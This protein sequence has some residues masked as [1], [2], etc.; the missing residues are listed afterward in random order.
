[1]AEVWGGVLRRLKPEA[2]ERAVA[3][4]ADSVIHQSESEV[5][6]AVAWSVVYACKSVSQTLHTCTPSIIT[7]LLN[8]HLS[9]PPSSSA[10]PT[11]KT[12]TLLRRLFTALIHHVRNAENFACV[13]DVLVDRFIAMA[14]ATTPSPEDDLEPLR[15]MMDLISIPAAVRNGSRLTRKFFCLHSPPMLTF[16]LTEKHAT[17]LLA[18]FPPVLT[19][20]VAPP[21]PF[22]RATLLR[23]AT[24]LLTASPDANPS[25]WMGKGRDVLDTVWTAKSEATVLFAISLTGAL[26]ELGW[27]GWRAIGI[28]LLLRLSSKIL[29]AKDGVEELQRRTVGLIAELWRAKKLGAG[30]GDVVWRNCVETWGATQLTDILTLSSFFSQSSGISAVLVQSCEALLAAPADGSP[31][32]AGPSHA[33]FVGTCMRALSQRSAT[34][35]E[36]LDLAA[37][38]RTCTA[39]GSKW[40]ESAD[41]LEALAALLGVRNTT[42]VDIEEIYPA[43]APGVLSH[44]RAL[45]LGTLR[46]LAATQ[47]S[48]AREVVKRCLAGEE[49]PLEVQGVRERVLRIGRVVTVVKDKQREADV[50]PDLCARWLIA[51]LK[52]N[53]R[54][55]WSPAAGALAQ[56]AQ[57]FGDEIWRL[58]FLELQTLY[59]SSPPNDTIE[60]S[61]EDV[62]EETGDAEKDPWEEE[63]TW[64]DPS[65][66]KLRGAVTKWLSA[67]HDVKELVKLQSQGDR[68]DAQTYESQLLFALGECPTLV[69]K[70]NRDIVPFFLDL[71]IPGPDS[72][73]RLPRQK[74]T[75]W[76]TLF[77]K[78]SNPKALHSTDAL[79]DLYIANL[80]H[81]DRALQSIAL[82]CIL[83]YKS[84]HLAAYESQMR[85]FLDDTRWRD[86]L[87][88]LDLSQVELQDRAEVVP[89]ITRLLFGLMLEKKGRSRGADRRAAVLGVLGG[90]TDEE[91]GLVVDLMLRSL[92]SDSTTRQQQ[93]FSVCD[94]PAEVS[95]KQQIGFIGLLGDVIRNLGPRLVAYWP[96][97]LGTTI[98]F[99][100]RA[101]ARINS[102]GRAEEEAEIDAEDE[103]DIDEN[104]P[105]SSGSK[106]LRSIRQLGLKRLAD[107]LRCPVHFDYAPYMQA[108]FPAFISPQNTQAPSS[109]LELFYVWTLDGER[110]MFLTQYDNLL[111]PKIYDCLIAT[112]VKP[113]VVSKIFDIVEKLLA[114]S[115]ID[116]NVSDKVVK[117]HVSLLLN[118]LAILVER[119]KGTASV[120]SQLGQRQI[121]ILSEI[122]Q[123]STDASQAS[124]LLTLFAPLLR[125]PPKVVPEKVKVN[126]LNIIG[127]LMPLIPD[128]SVPGS[129]IYVKTFELLSQL[130]QSLRFRPA[131]ISLVNSLRRLSLLDPSLERLAQILESL[132]AYSSRRVDEPDFDRRLSAFATLNETLFKSLS[133]TEWL[134]IIYNPAELAIRNN[135][136]FAMRHFI[137]LVAA[138]ISP[139]F[140]TMFNKVLFPG[141]KNGLRSKNE[142]VRSEI[143]GVLAYAVT[144]CESISFLQEM[145]VL[146]AGGDEEANFF[147]NIHHIQIHR[148]SRAL[149]RLADQCDEGHLRSNTLAEI[150]VPLVG[151]YITA[152]SAVDHHLVTDAILTTGRM[153]KHLTWGAYY[154]LVQKYL[155]LSRAKD[156]SERVYVRTVVS[157]LDNFH[158]PMEEAIPVVEDADEGEEEENEGD[159][160]VP[161]PALPIPV[162][163]QSSARIADAVNLRL[164]PTLLNH[165]EKRDATT[166]D[167]TRIPIAIGIVKVAKYLPATTR[168]PQIARLL[169][170]LSQVLRSKSQ[171]TRDLTRDTLSRIAVSLGPS[172][173]PLMLR[174]MRAALLRGPQL[175]VLAY[176]THALLVHVSSEEHSESFGNLDDCVNDVAYIS[177]EVIFGESAKDVMADEFKTKMR[178]VR[179]SSAKGLDAFGIVAKYIT[180]PRISSLL[181]PIR[182]IMQQTESVKVMQLVE[183]VLKRNARFLKQDASPTQGAGQGRRHRPDQTYRWPKRPDHYANNSFRFVT[184]GLDLFN[185]ALR[186]N[187]LDF[188]EPEIIKRLESMVVVIGNTLYSSTSPV[189]VFGL[190]AAAGIINRFQVFVQQIIDIVKQAGS[191]ESEV[192]QVAFKSL[193]VILRDGPAVQ[194]YL[195]ELLTPDLE[196]PSR[197]ASVFT[198]L[199]AIVARKFVVPEIYDVMD[200][201][202]D[203]MVTSQSPQVQ[204][205]CRSGKGRLRNQM[206]FLAKNLSYEY[207]S[208]RKSVLELLGAVLAKFEAGLVRE[209]VDLLFV[210]LVMV[211]AN[212]DSTKCREMAAQL[213]KTLFTRLDDDRRRVIISHLHSWASQ[214]SQP[215]LTRVSSQVYGL[216]IDVLGVDALTFIPGMLEDIEAS[217]SRSCQQLTD[218]ETNEEEAMDVDLEWQLPYHSLIVLSKILRVFPTLVTESEK[219]KWPSIVAHLLF[220]HAWVRTASCRLLGTLFTAVPPAPPQ[221]LLESSPVSGAGMREVA[222]KLCTQ[223]KSEHLDEALSLQV[224]KNLFYIG[225]CFY[226]VPLSTTEEAEKTVSN[227]DEDMQ[228][229]KD[230]NPL[231]WLFS[232]LSYQIRS[233][234][235]A[236]RNRRI[237]L[238][239]PLAAL[240][241]FAAMAAYM[242]AGRLEKF[243]VHILTPAYRIAEDD[244]IRDSQMDEL[245]TVCIELQDL[246]QSKVGTTKFSSAYNQIRQSVL[247]V[248]RERKATKVLQVT[249]NPEAAARRKLQRNSIK[250][251]SR[252]RKSSVFA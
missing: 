244:T 245:K 49:V 215:Q 199:R 47:P 198:M 158:F 72:S 25:F 154:A 119:T 228:D 102:A 45:R 146:L 126:L 143:L 213:I 243:L 69:Q 107:F 71:A 28:P 11:P 231:P 101:Q 61:M 193:A 168:E 156:A 12:Y 5:Q 77:S 84:P 50:G 105:T 39:A 203:I 166:E 174:E 212:D 67:R 114:F 165:L 223:L 197:Q 60:Q 219:V 83:T 235:I 18:A 17:A 30:D 34:E 140:E 141:L 161:T 153:A 152:T 32:V 175:H 56:M 51:Q 89:V 16:V 167:T 248:Q 200:K 227:G 129:V 164:L 252:K 37:W 100:A 159:E 104:S 68:L 222:N 10:D 22:V 135:A 1:M 178:E 79:R 63:R 115:T 13:G 148:R 121:S 75:A 94:V 95:E 150:F 116:S 87:M 62:E 220:P 78:L 217:L 229:G 91:L 8:H 44:S 246:V 236:R 27:A 202:A 180:P 225:K 151:N 14:Q 108:A 134:P 55:L 206:N 172:Y 76:L 137:D 240:R 251:E 106:I 124:T 163:L 4:L 241:W 15:R 122:A 209:Y 234:H 144:K 40:A 6:D 117:P 196:E 155:R 58:V 7:P 182:A 73:S 149:R 26:A 183:D 242:D 109:L 218:V 173:L 205:L 21:S 169:T 204:E 70:H 90:C 216:V 147:N 9:A 185:T 192:V 2:K 57:R 133:Q 239:K 54:P 53:L 127:T 64:R 93:P 250:K 210:A 38:V 41:V 110:V 80:S 157:L 142:L 125:R 249:V 162:P 221:D 31:V 160:G 103:E 88:R 111:L 232:K 66:H 20:S 138:R 42:K 179:S 112:N 195:L 214:Y 123:Y 177:A 43:L 33:W 48:D 92:K 194:V 208:G 59:S 120:S 128:L 230:L 176:V 23:L 29:M 118:N 247:G 24:A 52:V 184:F 131:R 171:E 3:L 139:E 186:R 46:L 85:A 226:A 237:G 187:K 224:V 233:A 36:N 201:V 191:T 130:F 170:V 189:L 113:A 188:H 211:I 145:R 181:V 238:N 132:N 82:S 74:L 65:A 136:A 99:I 190:R 97:L 96:A 98:D 35:W 207:E 81:P 86:E 19:I